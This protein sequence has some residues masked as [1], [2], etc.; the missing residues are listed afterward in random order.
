MGLVTSFG[1]HIFLR[2]IHEMSRMDS[3][4]GDVGNGQ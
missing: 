2:I 3:A 4:H 1:D